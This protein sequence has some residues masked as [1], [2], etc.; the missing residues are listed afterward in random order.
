MSQILPIAAPFTTPIGQ[1]LP[2]GGSPPTTYETA[3]F[4]GGGNGAIALVT[5]NSDIVGPVGP[6]ALAYMKAQGLLFS[7]VI[8]TV[9]LNLVPSGGSTGTAAT[10]NAFAVGTNPVPTGQVRWSINGGATIATT[11]LVA[12]TTTL[13]ITAMQF[14]LGINTV[15]A[16]YLGDLI[17]LD[18]SV[19]Q[20]FDNTI[21]PTF[22]SFQANGTNTP[23]GF[24]Q[25][26]SITFVASWT[27]SG[28]APTGQVK[29]YQS[30]FLFPPF[31]IGLVSL[32]AAGGGVYTAT[33]SGFTNGTSPM[34]SSGNTN[35]FFASFLGDVDYSVSNTNTYFLTNGTD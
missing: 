30:S 9:S 8:P 2:S 31:Q 22:N 25:G 27:F 11:T 14:T 19:S 4:Q 35:Q 5:N 7:A 3:W 13:N 34:P 23:H 20:T 17:Y 21:A 15:T 10:F 18:S 12:G 26:T 33:F 24:A 16:E 29:L 28:P 1:I 6:A 32:V